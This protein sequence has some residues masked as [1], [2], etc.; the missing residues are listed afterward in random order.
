MY[1]WIHGW[2]YDT[3]ST[4]VWRRNAMNL[5][6]LCKKELKK[7]HEVLCCELCGTVFHRS[8]MMSH[9]YS[10]HQCPA[11][12]QEISL[13][14]MLPVSL[15]RTSDMS[16]SSV[17]SSIRKPKWPD[18]SD[19]PLF[20]IDE[21]FL[22]RTPYHLSVQRGF[23]ARIR[24]FVSEYIPQ[25]MVKE[26]KTSRKGMAGIAML[27]IAV[28]IAVLAPVLILYDP[29]A[30]MSEDAFV[31]H[32]PTLHYPLGTDVFGR[33]IFSQVIWG[34]RS[35]LLISVPSALLVGIIGTVVGLVSGYY[36]GI[37][38]AV[39]QRVSIT[40]LVWPSV[41]L[42]ALIVFSWGPSQAI[43][44]VILG[45]AFTL[46]PTTARAIRAEVM[47]LRGQAF[48]ES[49]KVSGASPVR[50]IFRH[51][52]PRVMHLCFLYMTLAVASALVLEAT[53]NFLGL[54]S[55][56]VITWGQMLS[57]TY[58]A[59]SARF[60]LGGGMVWWT[61]APPA[62]AIAYMVFSFF[63][64]SSGLQEAMKIRYTLY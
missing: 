45:V 47:S 39:L 48:V 32:P 62:L 29:V 22:P 59:S 28:L 35:A 5:C 9:L 7:Y 44:A 19:I 49:A 12:R 6:L 46:W 57:F 42:V 16:S 63:L 50:I 37:T 27:G 31:Y 24:G 1:I 64:I 15:S 30:Y 61:I 36:G 55:P 43:P 58:H 40:F 2:E 25:G 33:D 52:L 26:F 13:I 54:T 14:N 11:C 18:I 38:D 41:P 20:D 21:S 23:P 4:R 53:F 60:S 17:P 34:F 3:L 10:H 56:A 51:I 8:C